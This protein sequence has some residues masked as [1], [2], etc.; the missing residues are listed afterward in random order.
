MH[1]VLANQWY[2]PDSGW[3]GVAMWNYVMAHAYRDLGHRVSVVTSRRSNEMPIES[4]ANGIRVYCLRVRDFPQLRRVPLLR[5]FVR[6]SQQ[7]TYSARVNRTLRDLYARDQFDVVEFADVNAEGF[8]YSRA[9]RSAFVVRCHTPTFVLARYYTEH[10]MPYDTRIISR[11]E[12]DTIRRANALT[13]PSRDMARV[14]AETTAVPLDRIAVVPNALCL[15]QF[16]RTKDQMDQRPNNLTILFVGRLERVKGVEILA[17]AIPQ[18]IARVPGTRFVFIGDDRPSARS[19]SQRVE[20][21]EYLRRANVS[22]DVEF[23]GGVDRPT[24]ERWYAC[25]DI[26]VV[27][28]L[29]YESFSYT[30][31]QAMAAGKPVVASRIGGIPE[32]VDDGLSGLIVEPGDVVQLAKAIVRLAHDPPLRER[33]G[34]AGREK[35]ARDFNP[36]KVA[37]RNLKVYEQAIQRFSN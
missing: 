6:P 26:C 13:T 1:I 12:K 27:P 22:N 10:E 28:S 19:E 30:C 15:A 33:M 35:V 36:I 5:R 20:L 9:P 17:H 7:L 25:A 34:C 14:V 2:P 8:F 32:T 24:L 21:E 3:G 11:C 37:E 23:L 31:A 29:L 4:D 16:Q 18:V